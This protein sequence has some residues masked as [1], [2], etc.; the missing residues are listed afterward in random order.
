[1]ATLSLVG[2]GGVTPVLGGGSFTMALTADAPRGSSLL[3][4]ISHHRGGAGD[5]FV[6]VITDP[7][8]NTYSIVRSKRDGSHGH[9]WLYKATVLKKLTAGQLLTV[10]FGGGY[11]GGMNMSCL[12]IKAD[13]VLDWLADAGTDDAFSGTVDVGFTR[14]GAKDVWV[15]VVSLGGDSND[16]TTFSDAD[17]SGHWN[18]NQSNNNQCG[19]A[20]RYD[21]PASDT[22]HWQVQQTRDFL[23]SGFVFAESTLLP[24]NAG[25][26]PVVHRFRK[27]G[28]TVRWRA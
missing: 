28:M 25:G 11:S 9:W 7:G 21:A 17:W 26:T 8:G 6:P 12:V 13:K 23:G 19:F 24:W 4:P 14:Q 15:T 27:L 18:H 3:V 2:S 16:L 1:V 10:T 22:H 5:S 20:W